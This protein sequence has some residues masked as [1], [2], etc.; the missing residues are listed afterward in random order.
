MKLNIKA[1]AITL[2]L[3]WGLCLFL[4]TWWI[5]LFDGATGQAT[6]LS[7]VYR[8]FN[9]SATGSFIG[10]AWGLVDGLIGGAIFAWLYNWLV[11]RFQS[12][13]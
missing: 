10:L 9:I 5:I 11:D 8:G 7:A 6:M 3:F 13:A 12:A 2:G 4:C 1:F